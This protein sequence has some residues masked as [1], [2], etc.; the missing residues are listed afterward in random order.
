LGS[1]QKYANLTRDEASLRVFN[2]VM[3][4][5]KFENKADVPSERLTAKQEGDLRVCDEQLVKENRVGAAKARAAAHARRKEFVDK[6]VPNMLEKHGMQAA[7][8]HVG[9]E[10]FLAC[11]Q[12]CAAV[13]A[14]VDACVTELVDEG[15]VA[16]AVAAGGMTVVTES[17]QRCAAVGASVDACV[18]E[19]VDEGGV[20][21]AVGSGRDDD[22]HREC[23]KM[24]GRRR[25][26]RCR[27]D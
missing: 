2:A 23:A 17:A 10:D 22:G 13:G 1:N 16:A 7:I 24:R 5:V 25:Q 4:A 18:T 3:A 15:G 6:V 19:L 12:R 26:R 8:D 9:R 27:F 20:A 14:S 21:A 11:A